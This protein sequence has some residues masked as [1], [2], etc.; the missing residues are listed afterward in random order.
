MFEEI[1]RFIGHPDQKSNFD[2]LFGTDEW[3]RMETISEATARRAFL[4]GLYCGS[5]AT[6]RVPNMF[7]RSRC[8]TTRM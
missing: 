8:A 6:R 2:T 5:S 1:N 7:A 3:K 4:H